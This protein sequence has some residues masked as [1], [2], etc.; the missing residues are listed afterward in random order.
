V[1]PTKVAKS[2]LRKRKF[3]LQEEEEK[4][5]EEARFVSSP[6]MRQKYGGRVGTGGT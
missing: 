6:N 4:E 1:I 2:S 5:E 3:A